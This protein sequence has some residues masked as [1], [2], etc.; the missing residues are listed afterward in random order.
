MGLATDTGLGPRHF[1]AAGRGS[2]GSIIST[3]SAT[4]AA[5]T[6]TMASIVASMVASMVGIAASDWAAGATMSLR[7]KS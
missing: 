6:S 4:T 5:F 1:I 3:T 7:S 2:N